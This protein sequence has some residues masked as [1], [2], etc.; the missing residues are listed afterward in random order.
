MPASPAPNQPVDRNPLRQMMDDLLVFKA[1]ALA[2]QPGAATPAAAVYGRYR[3]SAGPKAV[4]EGAFHTMF[5]AVTNARQVVFGG[6]AH[7]ADIA[8]RSAGQLKVVGA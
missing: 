1:H 6:V 2:D 4:D 8:L 7:Y 3:E 5:S